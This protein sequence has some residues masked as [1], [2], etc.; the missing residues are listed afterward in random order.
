MV[1]Y[2]TALRLGT[3]EA[4]AIFAPLH[5]ARPQHP[6]STAPLEL[7]RAAKTPRTGGEHDLGPPLRAFL[8]DRGTTVG[9]LIIDT[10]TSLDIEAQMRAGGLT[11][12]DLRALRARLLIPADSANGSR[13]P[14]G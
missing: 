5:P 12:R 3:A 6:T 13:S 11:D 7:G 2:A 9:E 10:L 14:R 1:K 8:A 4:E